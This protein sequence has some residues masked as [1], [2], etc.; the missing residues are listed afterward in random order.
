V[1][2]LIEP[3]HLERAAYPHASG[4]RVLLAPRRP[5]AD[6]WT[7]DAARGL[8]AALGAPAVVDGGAV[9][10]PAVR[11]AAAAASAVLL[12]TPASLS[13]ARR[14]RRLAAALAAGARIRLVIAPERDGDDLTSR[15][16]GRATDLVVGGTL[17]RSGREAAELAAGRWPR[18]RRGQLARAVALLAEAEG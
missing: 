16:L 5:A 10:S 4:L 17:P 7:D 18:R 9:L 12:V 13:G 11:A 8:V 14:S 6:P 15:A 2:D 1:A 3:A